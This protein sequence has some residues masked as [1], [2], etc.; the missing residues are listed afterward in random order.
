MIAACV[1]RQSENN[2]YIN[3]LIIHPEEMLK[4]TVRLKY[5]VLKNINVLNRTCGECAPNCLHSQRCSSS[6]RVTIYSAKEIII[7]PHTHM[8]SV[9]STF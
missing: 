4:L 3:N 9:K 8:L 6:T 7:L 1:L 2:K 5:F